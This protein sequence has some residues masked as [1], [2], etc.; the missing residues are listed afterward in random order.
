M[1]FNNPAGSNIASGHWLGSDGNDEFLSAQQSGTATSIFEGGLGNDKYYVAS[2]LATIIEEAN[3]GTDS[4]F[5]TTSYQLSENLEKLTITGSAVV[6]ATGNS[7]NNQIKGNNAGNT[8]SGLAGNDALS[9]GTSADVL[10]GGAGRDT[11]TGGLGMDTFVFDVFETKAN[12]DTIKDFISG[13]D[14]IEISTTAFAALA[15]FGVGQLDA[16]ELTLG[17]K[18]VATDDHLIYDQA[19]GVR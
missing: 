2:P 7:G 3:A 1:K 9:G 11:L 13:T 10:V 12:K 18:A 16:D 6:T 8:L 5:S 19:K 4:V 14:R 15:S 17:T